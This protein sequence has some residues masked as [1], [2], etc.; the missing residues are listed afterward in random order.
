MG[1]AARLRALELAT[2]PMPPDLEDALARRWDE[3]PGRVKTPAQALGRR[4]V[5]CEG[6][7]GVFPRCNLACTPCYHSRD[8]NRVRVDGSHTVEQVDRQMALL[9]AERGPGQN[10]QLI[11][12]EV[13]LL[14]PGE[15]AATLLAM[16]RHGRKPMSMS[17]GDFDYDYLRS[18]VVGP[19]GQVR[20][21][22]VSFAG[23]FDSLMLGRRGLRRAATEAELNPFRE[24]FCQMFQ[25]LE[26]ETGVGHYLAHNMTVT[27]AN[28]DQ[29]AQVVRDCRDMGFRMFSFQPAAYIGN[30][31]RWKGGAYRDVTGDAVW[32]E[33]E[34]GAGSRLPYGAFQF[35][36]TRCNRTAYGALVGDRWVP[37]LDDRSAVDM[38]VRDRFFEV[39]GGMDFQAPLIGARLAR[40][41]APHPGA[42]AEVARFAG[43]FVRRAGGLR[44]VRRTPPRAL[45]FVMHSF[46]DAAVVR[47]A[48]EA[49]RAGERASDGEV[50][51]A[52]ERLEACMYHMA[53]PETG[54]LVPACAQHSVLDPGE[55]AALARVLPLAPS[56]TAA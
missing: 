16:R 15:H 40:A 50:L 39:L 46:M 56:V 31:N 24:R 27:P 14:S 13:T 18:L 30:P 5:G 19:D 23:H 17:H 3:L 21:P 22:F 2:R 48:W 32:A 47:P 36:D 26:A 51:A 53:H 28:V 41:L 9:R 10:A 6:T 49:I 37:F 44:A 42:L 11:G 55:N 7:H 25:R 20:L 43:R 35:G 38:R 33:I 8:A 54:E 52:Q 45:T 29:V 4:T 1:L 34:R 12:G